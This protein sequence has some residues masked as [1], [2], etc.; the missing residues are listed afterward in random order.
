VGLEST[1]NI[2]IRSLARRGRHVQIG[3][4]PEDPRVP[5]GTVIACELTVLGSHGMPARDY[6]E[7]MALVE[8]GKLRPQDLIS[9]RISL[10]EAPAA[11]A[12]MSGPHTQQGVTIIELTP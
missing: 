8:S 3:L 10:E 12:A 6:P 7:L 11:L 5:L 1:V 2:A 9:D 4:M